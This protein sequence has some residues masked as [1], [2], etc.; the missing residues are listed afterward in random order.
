MWPLSSNSAYLQ[1]VAYP[2]CPRPEV[3]G[4]EVTEGRVGE[5]VIEQLQEAIGQAS[6]QM[7]FTNIT[8]GTEIPIWTYPSTDSTGRQ[9]KR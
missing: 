3:L 6:F 1:P 9:G 2:P 8:A 5:E 4:K 7:N